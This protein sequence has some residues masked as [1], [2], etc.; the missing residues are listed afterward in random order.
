MKNTFKKNLIASALLALASTHCFAD[1]AGEGASLPPP[2]PPPLPQVQPVS[3]ENPAAAPTLAKPAPVVVSGGAALESLKAEEL[4]PATLY[5]KTTPEQQQELQTSEKNSK[6]L[7]ELNRQREQA[8]A[9]L[10][11]LKIKQE[12][13]R[14]QSEIRKLNGEKLPSEIQAAAEQA[15]QN[16]APGA[17]KPKSPLEMVYVTQIYGFSGEEVVTV[18]YNNSIV[19]VKRGQIV[20]DGVRMDRVLDNG[21]VFSYKGKLRTV[22]LTTEKQAEARSFTEVD[23]NTGKSPVQYNGINGMSP[24]FPPTSASYPQ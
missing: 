3:A 19:K 2:P 7:D 4:A 8:Q 24:G 5:S 14:T 21:A 6:K 12:K 11:I 15:T 22:L 1:V 10:E 17:Q 18:Y 20:T 16:A 23:K 13:A 9:E